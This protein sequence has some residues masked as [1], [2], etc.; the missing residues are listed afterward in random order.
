[1]ASPKSLSGNQESAHFQ[2]INLFSSLI[3]AVEN[4]RESLANYISY[5]PVSKTFPE[6]RFLSA[7]VRLREK[8]CEEKD[9][10]KLDETILATQFLQQG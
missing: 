9:R 6:D 5:L 8:L 4:D 7:I 10:K 1:V 3:S 2:R